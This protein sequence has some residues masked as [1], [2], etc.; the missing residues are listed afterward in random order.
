M[1]LGIKRLTHVDLPQKAAHLL[2][3]VATQILF[4]IVCSGVSIGLRFFA[5]LFLP[6]AGP[7][8]LT[9]P[10][11]LVATLFG[12]WLCG[13]ITETISSLYAWYFVLPIQG[14]FQ[15]IAAADGPRVIANMLA[16]YFVVALAELFRRAVRNALA[17]RDALLLEL[18]HRVKNNF[19]SIASVLRLQVSATD[20]DDAKQELNAALGRVESFAQAY[21]FLYHDADYTGAVDMRVYLEG[22]C[23][24]LASSIGSAR[25]VQILCDTEAVDMPR[26][27]AI[28]VGLL[29]NE[30]VN[31]S[32]K[33]A[34]EPEGGGEIRVR[35][36]RQD[37][38]Y[39]LVVSDNGRGMTGEGRPGSLG[40]RLIRGLTAQANGTLETKSG[41]DG[42][43]QEFTFLP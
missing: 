21:E 34:F 43:R 28:L 42:T 6:G 7:F 22:L 2:P 16:G 18:Q 19:A 38:A 36:R 27:R 41:A 37:G 3:V 8:A 30:V 1:R 12:R 32:I 5:D 26:D 31:N 40:M 4:A 33:H 35:F 23:K 11:V 25:N 29:V 9:I 17:D 24:A 39:H 15:F 13:A 10:A 14:S 20:S